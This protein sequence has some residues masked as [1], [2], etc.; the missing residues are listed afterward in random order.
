MT[1]GLT[2]GYTSNLNSSSKYFAISSR[3]RTPTPLRFGD[4]VRS[5]QCRCAL[6]GVLAELRSFWAVVDGMVNK[7]GGFQA[8]ADDANHFVETST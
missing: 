1:F 7:E 4:F 6:S 8:Q 3:H 2:V 5:V